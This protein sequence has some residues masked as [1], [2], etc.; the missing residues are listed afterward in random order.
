MKHKLTKIE[1]ETIINWNKEED[2]A[3]IMT[4]DKALQTKIEKVV[5]ILPRIVTVF[6]NCVCKEYILP[7]KLI[8]VQKPYE[9]QGKT[10]LV[11]KEN[12]DDV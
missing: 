8:T 7:K 9:F 11:G 1:Q 2:T 6:D 12:S 3:S 5:K 10:H 4:F